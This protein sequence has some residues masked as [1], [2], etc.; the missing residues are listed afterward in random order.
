MSLAT[1]FA[2]MAQEQKKKVKKNHSVVN[3]LYISDQ[4]G[5]IKHFSGRN[6]QLGIEVWHIG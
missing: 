2:I 5:N 3:M 1:I 6:S 4:V